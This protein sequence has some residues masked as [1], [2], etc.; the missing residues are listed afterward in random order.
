MEHEL[1]R[2]LNDHLAGSN[3]AI[4]LIQHIIDTMDETVARDYFF[5]LKTNVELDRALLERLL[6]STGLR[7]S[8]VINTAGNISARVGFLKLMWE[9][10]EAGGLG[11]LEGL[12]I[13]AL[14]IQGKRMLWRSLHE[15]SPWFPEWD[16]VDFAELEREAVNQRDG[17]E[18]LRVAAAR[19]TLPGLD[20][21]PSDE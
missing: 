13:L 5:S 20:R 16:D 14:G 1:E 17:V 4:L 2:Y 9:G 12:E 8:A 7:T 18:S 15:V 19:K 11:L 6:T 21:R 3:G 10:F